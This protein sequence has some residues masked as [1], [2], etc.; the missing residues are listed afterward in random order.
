MPKCLLYCERCAKQNPRN[1]KES[2]FEHFLENGVIEAYCEE[3]RWTTTW[4][5]VVPERRI[6]EI[7]DEAAPHRLLAIDD[8]E[9][10]LRFIEL[11]VRPEGYVVSVANRADQAIKML[12]GEKFD[13]IVADIHMPGFDGKRLFRFL[14]VHLPH[15]IQKVVFLTGDTSDETQQFLLATR[16][17]YLYKPFG[18]HQL[19]SLIRPIG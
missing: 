3:C 16:C 15:Y 13:I 11:A 8:D 2:D 10:I 4:K 9:D 6:P 19:L 12:Q 14:A 17:P 1:L 18:V 7:R 5:L